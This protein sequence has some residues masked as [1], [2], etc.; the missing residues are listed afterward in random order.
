M[1]QHNKIVN[2]TIENLDQTEVIKDLIETYKPGGFNYVFNPCQMIPKLEA[3]TEQTEA[4]ILKDQKFTKP[5]WF[6]PPQNTNFTQGQPQEYH[7]L[8]KKFVQNSLRK[9]LAGLLRMCGFK[10][11]TDSTLILFVDAIDEFYKNL[12]E[13]IHFQHLHNNC[14]RKFDIDIMALEKSYYSMTKKSLLTLYNY[15]KNEM[16]KKNCL[17][18]LDLKDNF[19]EYEK[20]IQMNQ[21]P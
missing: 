10:N 3:L 6:I 21:K 5:L 4:D 15:Y 8:S 1:L 11:A 13:Q 9:S 14:D 17:G 2:Q 7:K 18:I 12:M 19:Q 20:I 16:L